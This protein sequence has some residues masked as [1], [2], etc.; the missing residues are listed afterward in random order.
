LE[1][2]A[3]NRSCFKFVVQSEADIEEVQKEYVNKFKIH[4]D[5]IWLMPCCGSRDELIQNSAQVVEWCKEHNYNYSPRL[6]LLVWN[7]ALKV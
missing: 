4:R 3:R 7:K 1:W 6:Q 5:R 2:H